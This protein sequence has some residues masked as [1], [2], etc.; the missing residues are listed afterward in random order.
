MAM[1]ACQATQ[2]QERR[3]YASSLL[4][5]PYTEL[6]SP[7]PAGALCRGRYDLNMPM[8]EFAWERSN[9]R[10]FQFTGTCQ[11]ELHLQVVRVGSFRRIDQLVALR[12]KH[13]SIN[14]PNCFVPRSSREVMIR[15]RHAYFMINLDKI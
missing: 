5:S 6:G 13:I 4:D 15:K 8:D 1:R 14:I 2:V 10:Q 12:R 11:E 3:D 9:R 7:L